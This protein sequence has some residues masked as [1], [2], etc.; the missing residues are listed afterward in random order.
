MYAPYREPRIHIALIAL[1]VVLAAVS[2]VLALLNLSFYKTSYMSYGVFIQTIEDILIT[3]L[4]AVVVTVQI[5]IIRQLYHRRTQPAP[6]YSQPVAQPTFTPYPQPAQYRP[7]QPPAQPGPLAPPPRP[8]QAQY[9]QPPSYIQTPTTQQP[10]QPPSQIP[11]IFEESV[12][13]SRV[14]YPQPPR[15]ESVLRPPSQPTQVIP[16]AGVQ[17]QPVT[18]PQPPQKPTEKSEEGGEGELK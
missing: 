1:A 13:G 11:A 17:R 9:P 6:Q 14:Q 2:I 5:L 18:R 3:C 16:R 15:T 10:A 12:E 4:L 7:P 8:P